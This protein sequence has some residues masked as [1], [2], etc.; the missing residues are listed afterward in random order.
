MLNTVILDY[1]INKANEGTLQYSGIELKHLSENIDYADEFAVAE[2]V[3][4]LMGVS[5][6]LMAKAILIEYWISVVDS[7]HSQ[8]GSLAIFGPKS[9]ASA[10]HASSICDAKEIPYIDIYMDLDSE[11]KSSNINFYPN[12][13]VLSQLLIDVLNNSNWQDFVILY[14]APYYIKRIGPLLEQRANRGIITIQPLEVGT[15]FR[16]NLRKI[17][18]LGIRSQNIIIEC[19]IEHLKEILEQVKQFLI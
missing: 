8:G 4:V 2:S 1:A 14:E 15:N 11:T 6:K 17:K 9:P 10:A 19:S 16:K 13:D 7:F 3:C 18:E 12:L 5:G